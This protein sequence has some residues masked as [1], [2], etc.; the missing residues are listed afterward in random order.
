MCNSAQPSLRAYDQN[1][2]MISLSDR[3]SDALTELVNIASGLTAAKLSEISGHRVLIELP[4]VAIHPM[5][6]LANELR[7]FVTGDVATVHQVFTGPVAGD[8][9]LFLTYD[10]AVNLANLVADGRVRSQNLE[11]DG[12]EVLTEV[13]NMLLSS[14]LGVF[15][16][17]LEVRVTFSLPWLRLESLE[18]FVAS[19]SVGGNELRYAVVITASFRLFAQGVDGRIVIALGVASLERL[20]QAVERWESIQGRA[21]GLNALEPA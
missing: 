19:L 10:G 13:G 5:D 2:C 12:Q 17:L 9:I 4:S 20:I 3:Q 7:S 6:A 14:C 18:R 21:T 16:N 8:A 1:L 15:G 11:S